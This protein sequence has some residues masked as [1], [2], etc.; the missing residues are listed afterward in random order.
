MEYI[1]VEKNNHLAR[2][3]ITWSHERGLAWIDRYGDSKMFMD[4][5][6]TKDSFEVIANA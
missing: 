2:H 3:C 5:T 1:V 6:L 4:K